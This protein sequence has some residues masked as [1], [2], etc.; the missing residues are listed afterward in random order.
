MDLEISNPINTQRCFSPWE[1]RATRENRRAARDKAIKTGVT[2][3]DGMSEAPGGEGEEDG[4]GGG[5]GGGGGREGSFRGDETNQG[6]EMSEPGSYIRSSQVGRGGSSVPRGPGGNGGRTESIDVPLRE[7]SGSIVSER[8]DY[9]D[10]PDMWVSRDQEGQP[11]TII[12]PLTRQPVP[13]GGGGG[14]G[15]DEMARAD[16]EDYVDMKS[17]PTVH[18]YLGLVQTNYSR[19]PHVPEEDA[20]PFD[21]EDPVPSDQATGARS[22][23]PGI[24][25]KGSTLPPSLSGAVAVPGGAGRR[26]VQRGVGMPGGVGRGGGAGRGVMPGGAGRAGRPAAGRGGMSPA[27][28]G[29]EPVKRYINIEVKDFDASMELFCSSEHHREMPAESRQSPPPPPPAS[30]TER[31]GGD[32]DNRENVQRRHPDY[33]NIDGDSLPPENPPIPK[34]SH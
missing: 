10:N 14:G 3:T 7:T 25:H 19:L 29:S 2:H 21:Y 26:H 27:G 33:I 32:S 12:I 23:T 16:P 15:E 8:Y 9:I 6:L 30:T 18:R 24:I 5:G 4:G 11:R 20:D 22:H 31:E 13:G 28:R 17:V 34:N 1:N